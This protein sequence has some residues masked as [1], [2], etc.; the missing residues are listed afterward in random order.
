M[1]D[2][3]KMTKEDEVKEFLNSRFVDNRSYLTLLLLLS[4]HY[5]FIS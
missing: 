2:T 3:Y 4:N 1:P 5:K